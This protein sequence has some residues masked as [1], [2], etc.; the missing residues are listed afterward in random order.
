MLPHYPAVVQFVYTSRFA[1]A[2]HI[3][4]RFPQY[5]TTRRTAQY[6]LAAIVQLGYLQ[7]APVRSTSPNFPF[8]YAATGRGVRLVADAYRRLGVEWR[9]PQPETA[10]QKGIALSSILHE[11]LTT[12]FDLTVWKTVES[13]GDLTRLFHER[14]Y[15]Q[16]EKQLRFSHNGRTHRIVPD[17]GFLLSVAD[18][19][20]K[21]PIPSSSLLMHFVELDNGTMPLPR[22]LKKF[23]TYDLWARSEEG[24]NYLRMLFTRYGEPRPQPNFRLLVIAHNNLRGNNDFR[25]LLDLFMQ[26]LSLPSTM[27]DRIWFTTAE[28]I[29]Q[30]QHNPSSLSAP[31]WVRARDAKAWL[32]AYRHF[33]ANLSSGKSLANFLQCRTF[34][35]EQF[36]HMPLH[37][38]FPTP[39]IVNIPIDPRCLQTT[40]IK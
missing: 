19:T 31:L 32:S 36:R 5:L 20:S 15:F 21:R 8:V 7:T 1:T 9:E 17:S 23:E 6:Q 30:E 16:R 40:P 18:Q 14:R 29:R 33:A 22:I 34:V 24:Q 26:T 25:R 11:L 2:S 12:E 4:R 13:R 38:V 27:R 39:P 3:Q 28:Q 35:A 37:P 10:K